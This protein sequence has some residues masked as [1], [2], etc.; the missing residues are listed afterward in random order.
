M[1]VAESLGRA[2]RTLFFLAALGLAAVVLV[3]PVA[4][5]LSVAISLIATVVGMVLPFALIGLALWVPYQVVTRGPR[6]AFA[7]I[8]GRV[9]SVF[10][11]IGFLLSRCFRFAG[12][13]VRRGLI[14]LHLIRPAAR[15]VT[16]AAAD[17]SFK[18]YGVAREYGPV[19]ARHCRHAAREGEAMVSAA[20]EESREVCGRTWSWTKFLGGMFLEVVGAAVIGGVLV[21][22]ASFGHA[23]V[24]SHVYEESIVAGAAAGAV[25]GLL[26]AV[27]RGRPRASRVEG[28]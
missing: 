15:T 10:G 23:E 14:A 18:V 6:A 13:T 22:L 28:A 25:L 7:D 26:V 12:W 8:R 17:A 2:V 5:L 24:N 16:L 21:A 11:H 4:A 20:V 9:G 3:G 19:V 1:A 27:A